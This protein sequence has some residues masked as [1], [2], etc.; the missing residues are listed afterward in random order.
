MRFGAPR[1]A[2]A[3]AQ[4]MQK[5]QD[6]ELAKKQAE[7]GKDQIEQQQ[8]IEDLKAK[9]NDNYIDELLKS[10]INSILN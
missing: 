3:Q 6:V 5:V 7:I 2:D 4:Q 1:A 10:G 8:F 9:R